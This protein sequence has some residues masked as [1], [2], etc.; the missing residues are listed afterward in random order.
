MTTE[1]QV[2]ELLDN[3]LTVAN[4]IEE[5]RAPSSVGHPTT[6]E[7][8]CQIKKA[9]DDLVDYLMPVLEKYLGDHPDKDLSL[10]GVIDGLAMV[11]CMIAWGAASNDETYWTGTQRIFDINQQH[12]NDMYEDHQKH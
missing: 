10:Q 1:N 6:A 4:M 7:E 9:S 12:V 5:E 3:A 11:F 2:R 8:K